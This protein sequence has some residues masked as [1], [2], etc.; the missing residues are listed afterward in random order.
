[1]P[2]CKW[3]L[4]YWNWYSQ[5]SWLRVSWPT[6]ENGNYP[7]AC[8]SIA[9]EGLHLRAADRGV[10]VNLQIHKSDILS[11]ANQNVTAGLNKGIRCTRCLHLCRHPFRDLFLWARLD[12]RFGSYI[13]PWHLPLNNAE[14]YN[15]WMVFSQWCQC[16]CFKPARQQ[17]TTI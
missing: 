13:T 1:M 11:H 10:Q 8:R 5:S 17:R 12:I 4:N 2:R 9:E 16:S 7:G 3:T 6:F 14:Q 15:F